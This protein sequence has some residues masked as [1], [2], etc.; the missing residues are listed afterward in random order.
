MRRSSALPS[1]PA[2]RWSRT[3]TTCDLLPDAGIGTWIV[4]GFGT[5]IMHGGTTAIFAVLGLAMLRARAGAM[6]PHAL[7]PGLALAVLLHSAYNH[8]IASPRAR[9]ARQLL[10]LPPSALRRLRAQRKGGRRLA[11]AGLRCRHGNARADQLR[12]PVRFAGGPVPAHAEGQVPRARRRGPAVLPAPLHGARAARQGHP[13]D[14]RERFRGPRR[15]R[16]AGQVRRDALSRTSI[17]KTGLLA[18]QP[19]C[20]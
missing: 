12:P 9:H 5:A 7:L 8:L 15:R 10:V 4:R 3:S 11:R 2:S 20:T 14:A 16:D 18:I 6:R 1:A 13:D 17:G 19:M